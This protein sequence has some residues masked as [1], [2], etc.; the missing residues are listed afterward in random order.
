MLAGILSI[1]ADAIITVDEAH[2]IIHFNRGAEEIFGWSAE[3]AIGQPLNVLLPERFRS[4][5]DLFIDEFSRGAEAARRMGHRREVA[6][7][8]RDGTEFPAE[9]SISKLDLPGGQRVF[10][11]VVRD[12]T[13]RRRAQENERFLAESAAR[14]TA[15]LVYD[16]VLEAVA[17]SAIPALGD[18]C[19]LD[20]AEGER[21][22]R[23]TSATE[24]QWDVRTGAGALADLARRYPLTWDSASP[25]LDVMRR[26]EPELLER[27]DESWLEA[28]EERAAAL[29]LWRAIGARSMFIVPLVVGERSLGALT[30]LIWKREREFGTD[31]RA[32][33]QKFAAQAAV[34][35]E[36][37]KLY[38]DAQRATEARDQVL[39]V[40][41]HDLRNPISAIAMCARALRESAPESAEESE[42]LLTTI[43]ESTEWMHRLIQ[44]LLD[45]A[46]IEAGRLSLD[47]REESV[48][49]LVTPAVRMFEVEAAQRRIHLASE[50]AADLPPVLADASRVIQVLGNLLRN[51]VKFTPEGGRIT[52][53]AESRTREVV[54][55]VSDN[56]SGIPLDEQPRVFDRYW[57]SRRG[58]NRRGTGLGLSIAKGIIE[59]HGGR[60]W[61]ESTPGRG[62]TF[63]FSLPTT[64][65]SPRTDEQTPRSIPRLVE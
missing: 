38:R 35:I 44:D 5:H 46:G 24:M 57:H 15:S 39:G 62:S 40:V 29:T 60:M 11:A 50:I 26:R 34:A 13:E 55:S 30:L 2:R 8:R 47:R 65:G 28:H 45:V 3:E 43:T 17:Q 22:R 42:N 31:V 10:T 25:A 56:G 49:A 12:V 36:N 33:A 32:L 27:V 16:D 41:S 7:L 61:L 59:A 37:A 53:A 19:L 1:A 58:G 6:G 63:F 4:R 54:M 23:L 14:M 48:A 9:A 21:F 20:V 18:A 64:G 51:A 52:V